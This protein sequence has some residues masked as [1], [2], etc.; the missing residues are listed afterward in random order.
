MKISAPVIK[1]GNA[2]KMVL[3]RM[4]FASRVIKRESARGPRR[5]PQD[6]GAY[7][8]EVNTPFLRFNGL[9]ISLLRK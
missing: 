7:L 9:D 4:D 2:R 5:R 6:I 1:V 3:F 8:S